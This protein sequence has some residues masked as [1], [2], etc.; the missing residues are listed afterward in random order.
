MKKN[1]V[2]GKHERKKDIS[3]LTYIMMK[4]FW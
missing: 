1:Q 4:Y 3:N 2:N